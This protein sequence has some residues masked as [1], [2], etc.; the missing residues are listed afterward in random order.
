VSRIAGRKKPYTATGIRRVPCCVQGCGKPSRYQ[1]QICADK[2]V[3]RGMCEEHDI[4][5]N[6][7][8]MRWAFGKT[9]ERDIKDYAKRARE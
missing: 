2:R 1:W 8:V 6:T 3:Y 5:L 7:M 9:R 4:E